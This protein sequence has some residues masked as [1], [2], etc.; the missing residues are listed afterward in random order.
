MLHPHPEFAYKYDWQVQPEQAVPQAPCRLRECKCGAQFEPA[1]LLKHYTNAAR[2]QR[3]GKPR[4]LLRCVVDGC[5][6]VFDSKSDLKSHVWTHTFLTIPCPF[7]TFIAEQPN[8]IQKHITVYH[9]RED[10]EPRVGLEC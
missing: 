9:P 7:C 10:A 8:S 4:R 6:E 3:I 5:D 1:D 2:K